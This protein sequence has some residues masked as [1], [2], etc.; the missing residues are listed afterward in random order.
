MEV[1]MRS[2]E[3]SRAFTYKT[4]Y[5]SFTKLLFSMARGTSKLSQAKMGTRLVL[6]GK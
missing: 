1:Q 6:R 4:H 5:N 2:G 3:T